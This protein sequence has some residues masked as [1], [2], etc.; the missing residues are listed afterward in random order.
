MS[1]WGLVLAVAGG[2]CGPTAA[3]AEDASV[4]CLYSLVNGARAMLIYCNEPLDAQHEQ[5][6]AALNQALEDFIR[7]NGGTVAERIISSE[8]A[9]GSLDHLRQTG[10][11]YC[12][13]KDY[14]FFKQLIANLL[15]NPAATDSIR[16][17]LKTPRD[18]REGGCI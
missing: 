10:R 15:D 14:P 2:L 3:T 4:M 6:Y 11:D 12:G 1:R 13:S 8:G 16:E 5:K 7:A 17:Q 9:Q 18:P